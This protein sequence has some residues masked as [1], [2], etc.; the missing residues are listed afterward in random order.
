MYKFTLKYALKQALPNQIVTTIILLL[1]YPITPKTYKKHYLM[2][3]AIPAYIG[4]LFPDVA[5]FLLY[6]VYR[7]GAV[8]NTSHSPN[9]GLILIPLSQLIVYLINKFFIKEKDMPEYWYMIVGF[10]SLVFSWIHLI[11]DKLGF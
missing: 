2:F 3:F 6:L 8:Y 9:L 7:D 1:L 10:V 4:S 11:V 5:F